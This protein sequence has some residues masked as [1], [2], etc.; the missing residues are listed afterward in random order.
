MGELVF[1]DKNVKVPWGTPC[2][3]LEG[4]SYTGS[5]KPT[6]RCDVGST[7]RLK[8]FNQWRL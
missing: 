7:L 8:D 4:G 5:G 6:D 3:R 2:A 1:N